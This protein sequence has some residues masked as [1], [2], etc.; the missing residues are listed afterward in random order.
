M[1][2]AREHSESLRLL[3]CGA[4]FVVNCRRCGGRQTAC[5]TRTLT[6][7]PR[8]GRRLGI[9]LKTTARFASGS[10][11]LVVC[12]VQL[13]FPGLTWNARQVFK[14]TGQTDRQIFPAG[15]TGV[16]EGTAG[17]G[18]ADGVEGI[19]GVRGTCSI[20]LSVSCWPGVRSPFP[21]SDSSVRW[22][23]GVCIGKRRV[24]GDAELRS[25]V[26]S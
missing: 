23:M 14:P 17:A 22:R 2:I 4:T 19:C 5:A 20:I 24:G 6:H 9:C 25:P 11:T 18:G 10:V 8:C 3:Y 12:L 21:M 7:A 26:A 16:P 13:R 15:R 1:H